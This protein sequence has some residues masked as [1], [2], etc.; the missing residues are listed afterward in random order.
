MMKNK[1]KKFN[2]TSHDYKARKLGVI[3]CCLAVASVGILI[4]VAEE[5]KKENVALNQQIELLLNDDIQDVQ[6]EE[7]LDA[8]LLQFN[9]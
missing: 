2:K 4:P 1:I 3:S 9:A 6:I 5:Y 8:E 7:L